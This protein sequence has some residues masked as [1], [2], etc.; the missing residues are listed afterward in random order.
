MSKDDYIAVEGVVVE[1]LPNTQFRVK[2]TDQKFPHL[3][4]NIVNATI[5]GKMRINYIRILEGDTVTVEISLYDLAK[6]RI[7]FRNK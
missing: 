2:I 3:I 5:S 1:T 6:G 4:G 7:T